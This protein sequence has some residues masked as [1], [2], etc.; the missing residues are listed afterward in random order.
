VAIH[1]LPRWTIV[2]DDGP[3][4]GAAPGEIASPNVEFRS[5]LQ[6]LVRL[7]RGSGFGDGRHPSTQLCLQAIAALAPRDRSWRLLDFGSGSGILSIAGVR[8]GATVDA[9]EIDRHATEHAAQNFALNDATAQVRQLT[10]LD[11]AAGPFDVVVAN[12]L[13]PVLTEFAAPLVERVASRGALVLSGLVSTD[14]PEVIDAYARRLG[15]RPEIYER[16]E[17]RALV[18]RDR[19]GR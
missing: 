4:G 6:R 7:T 2:P 13:R 12:I 14:A 1:V 15:A 11:D 8:L 9:V 5:D 17:W 19:A 16:D 10:A 18:W 3:I